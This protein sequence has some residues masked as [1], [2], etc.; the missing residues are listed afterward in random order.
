M[1]RSRKTYRPLLSATSHLVN[2][3]QV[4][5]DEYEQIVQFALQKDDLSDWLG[6]IPGRVRY[7]LQE[8]GYF[9]AEV[10]DAETK[11]ISQTPTEKI[12]DVVV[13]VDTGALYTLDAIQFSA[14]RAVPVFPEE[15]LRA[16]FPISDGE[17]L[18]TEK[19]RIGL[20]KLRKLYGEDGYI[21]FTPVP[22]TEVLDRARSVRLT[23]DLDEGKRFYSVI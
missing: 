2:L 3:N 17:L 16:Q 12:V 19:I 15:Q 20:E 5:A 6:G 8:R 14:N 21:N 7:A 11:V 4:P 9:R 10:G 13:R 22:N 1:L 18:D 23:V